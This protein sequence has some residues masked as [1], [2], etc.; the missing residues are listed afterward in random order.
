MSDNRMSQQEIDNLL[1]MLDNDG[2]LK[3]GKDIK[4]IDMGDTFICV[5]FWG[6]MT[7]HGAKENEVIFM[8]GQRRS[9]KHKLISKNRILDMVEE[10]KH[11]G[12]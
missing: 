9:C 2:S 11:R 5:Y 4:S 3:S 6:K 1:M 8:N 7:I 10:R 12:Y